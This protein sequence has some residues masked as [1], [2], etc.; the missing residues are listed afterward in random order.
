MNVINAIAVITGC[1][2]SICS[3]LGLVIFIINKFYLTRFEGEQ[4]K[5]KIDLVYTELLSIKD[6]ILRIERP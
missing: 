5:N 2:V 3:L 6:L 1:L 4:L